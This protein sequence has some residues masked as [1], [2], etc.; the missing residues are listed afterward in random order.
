MGAG[1]GRVVAD[2]FTQAERSEIMRR[3]KGRD[4]TP[5]LTLRRLLWAVGVRGYRLN[6]KDL[7]GRPDLVISRERIAIFVDGCFWHGCPRCYRRP[8][9]NRSYWD[10]KV[11]RNM[12]RDRSRRAKLKR[13]GW[14]VI[15]LWEHQ[16]VKQPERCVSKILKAIRGSSVKKSSYEI[17]VEISRVAESRAKFDRRRKRPLLRGN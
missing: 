14:K 15:R 8:S 6:R 9:S 11:D 7:P 2:T 3:V 16:V 4:T 13:L 5:E 1:R 12:R 10:L 17:A